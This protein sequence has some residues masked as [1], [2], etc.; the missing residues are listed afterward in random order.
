MNQAEE[1]IAFYYW[2]G[3]ALTDWAHV[4][5]SMRDVITACMAEDL[6]ANAL[7]VGFYTLEGARARRD[8]AQAMVQRYLAGHHPAAVKPWN[9]LI[10]RAQTA[11]A[12]RNKLAHHMVKLFEN[13][14]PGRR[15]ALEPAV[16]AKKDRKKNKHGHPVPL[17]GAQCLRDIVKMQM[18]FESLSHAL[19]N[20]LARVAGKELPFLESAERPSNPPPIHSLRRQIL[21]GLAHLLQQHAKKSESEKS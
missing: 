8:F 1:Q 3:K 12:L 5:S 15:F 17:P 9:D 4:E 21:E 2:I 10:G 6:A 11:T 13:N 18:E 20:F 7:S 14:T 16:F 19:D